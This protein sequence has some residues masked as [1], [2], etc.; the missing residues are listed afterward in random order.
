MSVAVVRSRALAGVSA[1]PVAVEVHLA[2][3]L[4]NFHLVGLP[5]TEVREARDRVRAAL[6]NAQFEFPSRKVTVNLA[7]ADL[8]KESGRFDLPIALAVLAAT[9]QIPAPALERYEFAGELALTGELRAIRGALAMVLSARRDGRAFVLPAA[10]ADEAALVRDVVVHPAQSLLAVCAHLTGRTPLAPLCASL[11]V[12]PGAT[13]DLADVRGQAQAKRVLEIAAA[14]GHSLLLIGP[15]GT[16]KSMLAQRLPGLLPPLGEDEALEAAAIASLAGRFVPERWRVRPF[17]APHH[18]ASGIAIVGGGSHARPGE[19]SL[20]HHGVLFLDELPEWDRRVLEVLR[21]PLE[22]GV[23]NISRAARQST[24]PAQFQLVAAMN[25]CPCG[26]YGHPGGR[27]RCGPDFVRRYRSRISGPLLDRI[28]L[29]IDVPAVPASVL[30][31][32]ATPAAESPAAQARVVAVRERQVT[33]QGKCNARLSAGELALCDATPGAMQ[34]LTRAMSRMQ[35]SAR[36]FH[37]VLKVARTIADLAG[38]ARVEA[39]HAAEALAYRRAVVER[40]SA[41]GEPAG[42]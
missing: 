36:A 4:P 19:I 23:I 41:C 32:T 10:S 2:N 29:A 21:E 5:L 30:E 24:F 20:A 18:T 33:R 34:T 35:L 17:R 40:E 28:D 38:D 6:Q 22:S 9:G 16:G 14:G 11:P 7:P 31:A 25:P 12:A 37:R 3:G 8:P 42:R 39:P 1:P 15:P 13:L 27:C 26:W